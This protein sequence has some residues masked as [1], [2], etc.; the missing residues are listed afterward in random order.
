MITKGEGMNLKDCL[1]R[2]HDLPTDQVIFTK[3]PWTLDSPAE[4]GRLD[5]EER[6][7]HD[8]LARG[9]SYFLEVAVGLEVLEVFGKFTPTAEQQRSLLMYYA[10]HDA[11]PDWL[12]RLDR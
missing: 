2:F 7:P 10:E 4:V 11:F 9:L 6:V 5:L 1:D 3:R 8:V 12:L